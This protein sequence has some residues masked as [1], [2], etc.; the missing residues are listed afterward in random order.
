M[1][2]CFNSFYYI[3]VELLNV[4]LSFYTSD[5]FLFSSVTIFFFFNLETKLLLRDFCMLKTM[6]PL[7][8]ALVLD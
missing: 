8:N 2:C 4:L 3:I 7:L 5:N 6:K 1:F